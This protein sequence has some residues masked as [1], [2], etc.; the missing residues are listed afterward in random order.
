MFTV[1]IIEYIVN[2]LESQWGWWGHVILRYLQLDLIVSF[3]PRIS[4]WLPVICI[5]GREV[6]AESGSCWV[7]GVIRWT[8]QE[9]RKGLLDR[10]GIEKVCLDLV[11]DPA[12]NQ[13]LDLWSAAV[14]SNIR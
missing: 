7:Q 1:L 6:E 12:N 9:Y 11:I 4:K 14:Y 13:I 5:D 2:K 10:I 3:I 8:Q